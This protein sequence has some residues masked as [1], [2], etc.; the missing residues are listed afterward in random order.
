MNRRAHESD[1]TKSLIIIYAIIFLSYAPVYIRDYPVW[2]QIPGILAAEK[3]DNFCN[4][5]RVRIYINR[6]IN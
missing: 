1:K 2:Q 4:F 5:G 3:K 6:G